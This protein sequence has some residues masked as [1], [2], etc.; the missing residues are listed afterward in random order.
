MGFFVL[1]KLSHGFGLSGEKKSYTFAWVFSFG[2]KT[3][4]LF[5]WF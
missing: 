4:A 5:A 1:R 2:E 3:H